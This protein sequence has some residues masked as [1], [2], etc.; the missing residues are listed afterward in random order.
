MQLLLLVAFEGKTRENL[1]KQLKLC[2]LFH[3]PDGPTCQKDREKVSLIWKRKKAIFSVATAAVW[4][5]TEPQRTALTF[6]PTLDPCSKHPL[7]NLTSSSIQQLQCSVCF[8]PFTKQT[9]AAQCCN[10]P[11]PRTAG[12]M[13]WV[14]LAA[15][16]LC[17]VAYNLH[18]LRVLHNVLHAH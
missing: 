15:P 13:S 2:S 6:I 7:S 1:N 10:P 11:S 14:P 12:L 16:C 8:Q 5:T 9:M 4:H 18:T 3:L 17:C